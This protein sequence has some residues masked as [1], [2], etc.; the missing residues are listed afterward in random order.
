MQLA[1]RRQDLLTPGVWR[2]QLALNFLGLPALKEGQRKR[3]EKVRKGNREANYPFRDSQFRALDTRRG[4]AHCPG[5]KIQSLPG[6]GEALYVPALALR[7]S[8]LIPAPFLS[9]P[10]SPCSLQPTGPAF[11]CQLP[12]TLPPPPSVLW[13]NPPYLSGVRMHASSSW[14]PLCCTPQAS[15]LQGGT[16]CL[17][18][19]RFPRK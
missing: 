2:Q 4:A 15:R 10:N 13:P 18:T 17:C 9:S 19:S 12:K 7:L 11:R 3:T 6:D 5:T 8:R 14:K 16:D 1:Q